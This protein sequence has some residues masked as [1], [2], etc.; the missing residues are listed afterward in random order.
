MGKLTF[1]FEIGE[2]VKH[3]LSGDDEKCL[4][5]GRN[6]FE[7][8]TGCII[9]YELRKGYFGHVSEVIWKAHG[10]ELEKITKKKEKWVKDIIEDD[11]KSDSIKKQGEIEDDVGGT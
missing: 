10:Y 5:V 11:E 4:V 9:L 2:F 1:K 6:Y 3:K 7:T 8:G